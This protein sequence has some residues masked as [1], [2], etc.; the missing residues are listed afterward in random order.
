M[1]PHPGCDHR[2]AAPSWYELTRTEAAL[3][4]LIGS[5]FGLRHVV[6]K[7]GDNPLDRDDHTSAIRAALR[8]ILLITTPI[9][10]RAENQLLRSLAMREWPRM[11][12][13][14]RDKAIADAMGAIT[15]LGVVLPPRI[16]SVLEAAGRKHIT[17]SK[18][19]VRNQYALAVDPTFNAVDQRVLAHMRDSQAL[20]IRDE[21][22]RRAAS[23]SAKA[24]QIAAR[25]VE[26]GLDKT[27][28]AEEMVKAF[29]GTNAERS[30]SYYR[31]AA[32]VFMGRARSYATVTSFVECEIA[33]S[34]I[35][36]AN[37]ETTCDF[38]RSLD[39]ETFAVAEQQRSFE[40]VA[41]SEDPE[42]VKFK[43]PF[44]SKGKDAAGEY[45]YFK[46]R[47]GSRTEVSRVIESAV[48]QKDAKGNYRPSM[49]GKQLS[50]KG[51]NTPPFHPH[52]FCLLVPAG[53][54]TV[55]QAS[56]AVRAGRETEVPRPP[57]K[58]SVAAPPEDGPAPEKAPPR[59][60]R[61]REPAVLDRLPTRDGVY[62]MNLS[63]LDGVAY[64]NFVPGRVE[65]IRQALDRGIKL[66]PLKM[67]IEENGN[68]DITD[69]NHR[70]R[71]YRERGITQ[72]EVKFDIWRTPG[73][74]AL[75]EEAA[76]RKEKKAPAPEPPPVLAPK[77]APPPKPPA[78]PRV[79]VELVTGSRVDHVVAHGI[80]VVDKA[81]MEKVLQGVFGPKGMPT[82]QTLEKTWS[83]EA[84]GHVVKI[85]DF[86][87]NPDSKYVTLSGHIWKDG[88]EIGQ[89]TRTF[90]RHSDNTLEVHHD[91]FKI[92]DKKEQGKKTG[93]AMLRQAIQTY[94]KLGVDKISVDT[95][96]VGRYA[97]ATF[98]YNW[99]EEGAARIQ[100][101][102][103][104]YL[105]DNAIQPDRAARIAKGV[106]K[107][108]W[109]VA[110]LDVDGKVVSVESERKMIDCKLGKAFLLSR[111]SGWSGELMLDKRHATYKRAKER[112]GL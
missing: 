32:S 71:V 70:L 25:G 16:G 83:S 15:G 66:P 22:G 77:P 99:N 37:H 103:T 34:E 20:Y 72:V 30:E 62:V 69:G 80:P 82:V 73:S 85:N 35:S 64:T 59:A 52:C 44:V 110:A 92:D 2:H 48:G 58:P 47:D 56:S 17:A 23:Y 81:R 13:A 79:P 63:A 5:T 76:R 42:D 50:A 55:E 49:S 94:E 111:D 101:D 43:Q 54:E 21:Y 104:K 105:V 36:A 89:I 53:L 88:V 108:S 46:N 106:S 45:L 27:D 109:D 19:A 60:R 84:A 26:E 40:D 29:R 95:A 78:P 98:G 3:D 28:I 112:L 9:E 41:S 31:M 74:W 107:R 12:E 87:G 68:V 100:K 38:C 90:R 39:G 75:K 4:G 8:Q 93:E 67:V 51:V 97:W 102:L 7:A 1:D 6:Q 10:E 11:T 18:Q 86:F 57:P 61:S 24:R 96:W 91:Y 33:Y 65:G 14:Q